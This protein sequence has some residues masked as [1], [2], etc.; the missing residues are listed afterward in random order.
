MLTFPGQLWV[1][2][3]FRPPELLMA[4]QEAVERKEA[5][6]QLRAAEGLGLHIRL[7]EHG[8]GGT[9]KLDEV[10]LAGSSCGR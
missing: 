5:L 2:E 1:G 8:P 10:T 9:L 3:G 7:I 4:E 6:Q